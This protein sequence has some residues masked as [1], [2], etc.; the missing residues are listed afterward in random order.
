[1]FVCVWLFLSVV[2]THNDNKRIINNVDS[3][4]LAG[5][6]KA[7]RKMCDGGKWEGGGRKHLQ[8]PTLHTDSIKGCTV[9]PA[10]NTSW[11]DKDLLLFTSWYQLHDG[12]TI[13]SWQIG[14]VWK[15]ATWWPFLTYVDHTWRHSWQPITRGEIYFY[16]Y[17]TS[18]NK[19]G[20][21]H[22][23]LHT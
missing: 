23:N 3:R 19:E 12:T 14:V 22:R 18:D 11:C 15:G 1:M 17:C 13:Y 10:I 20:L 21:C 2:T 9:S 5:P 4:Y 7:N 16:P 8:V 6:Y